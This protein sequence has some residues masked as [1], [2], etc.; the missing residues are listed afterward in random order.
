MPDDTEDDIAEAQSAVSTFGYK[1]KEQLG[2]GA[3]AT[4]KRVIYTN[5][6]GKEVTLAGKVMNRNKLPE[7]FIR[8]FFPR[9]LESL[10]AL[11]HPHIIK[12]H[13]ILQ[14]R[15]IV[16]IFMEFAAKGDLL[17]YILKQGELSELQ[18]LVWGSQMYAAMAYMQGIGL[19]N[20]DLKCE[21]MLLSGHYNLK[22]ADFGFARKFSASTLSTTYCGSAAYAAP[23]I[24][25]GEPY[26]PGKSDIWS[27]GVILFVML[28]GTMPFSDEDTA[29]LLS[30][31]ENRAWTW[32]GKIEPTLSKEVKSLVYSILDPNRFTRPSI[33]KVQSHPWLSVRMY[34]TLGGR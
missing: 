11:N 13:S 5:A 22:I 3:Y 34:K 25:R 19:C 2:S 6:A 33:K 15:N 29:Q 27:T 7:H 10:T 1:F 21:N 17:E 26:D 32:R 23:E 4:V 18:T 9:E 30:D 24:L 31:Q 20:R 12:V 14:R 16:F 8:K 28:C